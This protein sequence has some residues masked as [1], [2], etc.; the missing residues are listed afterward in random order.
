MWDVDHA[1]IDARIFGRYVIGN[2]YKIL[3]EPCS[4]LLKTRPHPISIHV[5]V[6]V[7]CNTNRPFYYISPK[8]VGPM[9]QIMTPFTPSIQLILARIWTEIA[10]QSHFILP[11]HRFTHFNALKV[12]LHYSSITQS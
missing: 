10:S 5:R 2:D 9:A 11:S 12:S 3:S 7:V 6:L 8:P 4:M 1:W